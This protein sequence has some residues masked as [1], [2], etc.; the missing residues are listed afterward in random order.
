MKAIKIIP[1]LFVSLL[2]LFAPPAEAVFNLAVRP[3]EGGSDLRFGSINS[4]GPYSSSELIIDIVSDVGTQ[5]Q[6]VQ[7]LLEPLA[8][9]RGNMIPQDAFYFYGIRGSNHLGTLLA[10]QE[11]P[12]MTGRRVIYTSNQTGNTDT[13]KLVYMLKPPFNVPAGTYRGRIAFTLE[14]LGG[15]A[16]PMTVVINILAEVSSEAGFDIR[17]TRGTKII[18]LYTSREEGYSDTLLVDIKGAL[19]VP[20]QIYQELSV[21]LESGASGRLSRDGLSYEVAEADQGSPAARQVVSPSQRQLVYSSDAQGSADTFLVTYMLGSSESETAGRYRST[22]RYSI[23]S[24]AMQ[25]TLE[26]ISL[27][28]DI[29]PVFELSITPETGGVIQ[30]RDLK[31]GD[32]PQQVE[33]IM[34]IKNNTG[35]EY[36][37]SQNIATVLANKAG[38]AVPEN[39]FT[40]KEESRDTKGTLLIPDAA[41]VK[42]GG[43]VLFRSDESGSGDIFKLIYSLDPVFEIEAGDYSTKITYSI[44]EL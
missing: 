32:K 21:P 6:I 1:V 30:F 26:T 12:L 25:E 24:Q 16:S 20:Y 42:Q 10:E 44:T 14:P 23:A 22:I 40:L 39:S 31:A 15:A 43:T 34:E 3:Y 35:K 11:T 5:Y 38:K 9:A 41:S 13:F 2:L 28:I 36:Q 17:T 27:E 4:F 29:A 19:G 33:V 8:N 7:T 37:V 18:S